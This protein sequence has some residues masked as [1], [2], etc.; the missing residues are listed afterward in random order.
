MS[1]DY[2]SLSVRLK[3]SYLQ[4]LQVVATRVLVD[5]LEI[6]LNLSSF[7]WMLMG[8]RFQLLLLEVH[9]VLEDDRPQVVLDL[10]LERV[11]E[12]EE[13]QLCVVIE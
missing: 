4:Q 3:R 10:L 7:R 12:I 1:E 6:V 11:V 9:L 5:G 13:N 2:L 8:V